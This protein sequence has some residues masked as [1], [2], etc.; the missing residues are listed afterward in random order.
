VIV[1]EPTGDTEEQQQAN[2]Q[3]QREGGRKSYESH[4]LFDI[5]G[6]SRREWKYLRLVAKEELRT[7]KDLKSSDASKAYCT[8]CTKYIT[9][10]KGNGNSVYRHMEKFHIKEM[11]QADCAQPTKKQKTLDGH[12]SNIVKEQNLRLASRDDRLLGDALLVKWTS[13]SLRPFRVVE[14]SGF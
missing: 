4:V 9:Y 2:G 6:S 13:E 8:L 5:K 11:D 1:S 14:D 10:T 3:L 12:F 7:K